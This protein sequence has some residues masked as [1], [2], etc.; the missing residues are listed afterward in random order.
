VALDAP[1]SLIWNTAT[2]SYELERIWPG[3]DHH[4]L[5]YI[6]EMLRNQEQAKRA[7]KEDEADAE[8]AGKKGKF[9]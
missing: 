5:A 1:G 6:G 8:R 3:Y 4:Y 7:A 9:E 2:R